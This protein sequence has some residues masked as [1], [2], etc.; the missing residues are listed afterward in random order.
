M[1]VLPQQLGL[2]LQTVQQLDLAVH[3]CDLILQV[4]PGDIYLLAELSKHTSQLPED[5]S[6]AQTGLGHTLTHP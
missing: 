5:Q 3:V 4:L 6:R 2:A 1:R